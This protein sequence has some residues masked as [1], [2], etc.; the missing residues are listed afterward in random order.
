[1]GIDGVL[2]KQI[3]K[4]DDDIADMSGA[5][6]DYEIVNLSE[7]ASFRATHTGAEDFLSTFESL[8]HEV[9]SS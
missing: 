3:F 1:V 6:V 2:V 8:F 7:Q 9:R 5:A 4:N